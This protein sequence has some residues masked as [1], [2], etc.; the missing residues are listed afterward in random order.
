VAP[1]LERH[2][3][4]GNVT[5]LKGQTPYVFWG[6]GFALLFALLVPGAICLW[7]QLQKRASP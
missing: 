3:L 4:R 5:P 2:V 1:A 6:D 7:P